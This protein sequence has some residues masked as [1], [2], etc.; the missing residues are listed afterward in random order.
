MFLLSFIHHHAL[1]LVGF[2][3]VWVCMKSRHLFEFN[4]LRYFRV[5]I[6]TKNYFFK[7]RGARY[8]VFLFNRCDPCIAC[9]VTFC[10]ERGQMYNLTLLYA[11]YLKTA[12][13]TCS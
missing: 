5:E 8:A 3:M 7:W 9:D 12:P 1:Y 4:S 6:I 2:N 11:S 13:N 10:A